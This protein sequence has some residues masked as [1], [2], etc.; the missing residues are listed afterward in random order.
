MGLR[1]SARATVALVAAAAHFL[2][3]CTRG[4]SA[5][6]ERDTDVG[7]A[8]ASGIDSRVP[9]AR[10]EPGSPDATRPNDATPSERDLTR[11]LDAA[12]VTVDAV[13]V[14][15]R[16]AHGDGPYAGLDATC[17]DRLLGTDAAHP[18]DDEFVD[19]PCPEF[20]ETG[21]VCVATSVRYRLVVR[22]S[23]DLSVYFAPP[24]GRREP[25]QWCDVAFI[26]DDLIGNYSRD[27]VQCMNIRAANI[28]RVV[29]IDM[30][31]NY[32]TQDDQSDCVPFEYG[33][34]RTDLL[35]DG[36]GVCDEVTQVEPGSRRW[37]L[38]IL[39]G[40]QR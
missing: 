23:E 20:A 2:A 37:P 4:E 6:T 25:G 38:T 40:R 10:H 17:E 13:A 32:R 5:R 7:G 3:G 24:V 19:L 26:G 9:D 16:V 34:R 11:P 33:A 31:A 22:A 14:D 18:L 29:E 27:A 15:G 39:Y 8:G 36:D 1:N 28:D 12:S 35:H 30:V 21:E